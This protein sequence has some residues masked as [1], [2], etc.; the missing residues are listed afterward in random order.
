MVEPYDIA[1]GRRVVIEGVGEG[2]V[3]ETDGGDVEVAL[4]EIETMRVP[5]DRLEP[6]EG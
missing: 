3:V 2:T 1:P 4:S 6:M 5:A